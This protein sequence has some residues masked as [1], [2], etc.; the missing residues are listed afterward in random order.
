VAAADKAGGCEPK[1]WRRVVA[2]ASM[3]ARELGINLQHLEEMKPAT[4]STY[5]LQTRIDKLRIT[6]KAST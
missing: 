4:R 5:I 3:P 6:P 1:E 2:L